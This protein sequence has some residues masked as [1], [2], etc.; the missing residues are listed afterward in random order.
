MLVICWLTLLLYIASR[1]TN[2]YKYLQC[3]KTV[4]LL[5]DTQ[6]NALRILTTIS[7]FT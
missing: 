5:N 1:A 4:M 3:H 6:A 7:K 2:L